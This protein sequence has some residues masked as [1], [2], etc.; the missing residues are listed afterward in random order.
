MLL[1]I[2]R[3]SALWMAVVA[4]SLMATA[5]PTVKPESVGLSSERLERLG[6]AVQKSIDD[7]QIAGAVTLVSRHGQIAW[8]KA[9]GMADREAN[10][11]MRPDEMFRICSM[12]KPITSVAVMMLYEEGKFLLDDPISKYI[13][14]F[15]NPKVLVKPAQGDPYTIPAKNE[16]TIRD[17][18]RHTSGVTYHW[19]EDLGPYYHKGNVA[20]GLAQYDGTIADSVKQLAQQPLLFNPGERWEYGLSVDVLGRLVEVV[21]GMPLDQFFKTRIFDPL[22]MTDTYFYPPQGKLDR[23]ATVYWLDDKGLKRFPDTPVVEKDFIYT[24]DYPY[25]GPKKLFSGGAGLISTAQD[26]L[27]FCQ[28][29][30][31]EGKVGNKRLLSRK[32][33]ELMSH[34]QLGKIN[35]EEGFGLGFGVDGVKSPLHE[36]GTPGEVQWGGFYYTEFVIDAKEQMIVIFMSQ[37]KNNGGATINEAAKALA[38]QAIID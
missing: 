37:L 36:I 17:L 22:G 18:L 27:R 8:F 35:P 31:D 7:K 11:A 2:A 6:A 10:K 12:T 23:L 3:R 38:F 32:S 14:E 1:K 24:A 19:N 9:Q 29:V 5:Q 26:Y 25:N 4:M 34:D 28:M 20:H 13:P 15:K 21:S 30:L 33:I 16:I